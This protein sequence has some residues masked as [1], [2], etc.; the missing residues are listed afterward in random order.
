MP[1]SIRPDS[2]KQIAH[3]DRLNTLTRQIEALAAYSRRV[4]DQKRA[5]L[6]SLPTDETQRAMNDAELAVPVLIEW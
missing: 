5:E 4:L 2:L 6:Y 3:V 1:T